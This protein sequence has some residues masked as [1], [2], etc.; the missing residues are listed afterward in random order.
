MAMSKETFDLMRQARR[1]FPEQRWGYVIGSG[2]SE[3]EF[4]ADLKK[5]LAEARAK[6]DAGKGENEA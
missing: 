4:V 3:E 1:E 6:R 2:L 5:R